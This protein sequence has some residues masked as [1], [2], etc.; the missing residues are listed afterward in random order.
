MLL[1]ESNFIAAPDKKHGWRIG[2]AGKIERST[3]AGKSWKEQKS[4]VTA[5]L[6]TGSAPSEKVCWIAGKAGTL[7]LTIDGGKHWKQLATPISE[8]LGGVRAL[9]AQHVFIWDVSR[10]KTFETSDGGLTWKQVADQ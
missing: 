7:L 1:L 4:G 5:D 2:P 6:L 10:V 8:D 3:D 9:D